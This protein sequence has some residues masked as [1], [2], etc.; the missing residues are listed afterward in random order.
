MALSVT[1]KRTL[2]IGADEFEAEIAVSIRV[3]PGTEALKIAFLSNLAS[4]AVEA[5]DNAAA[6]KAVMDLCSGCVPWI[7]SVDCDGE[8][9]EFP[10][11]GWA[12]MSVDGRA[13]TLNEFSDLLLWAVV[14]ELSEGAGGRQA[15]KSVALR[16]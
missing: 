11:G 8:P 6:Q 14:K 12:E 2:L 10:M 13:A 5:K 9:V 3:P 7:D 4:E 1:R 15:K 16:R